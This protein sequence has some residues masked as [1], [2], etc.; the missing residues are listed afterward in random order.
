[1]LIP[2]LADEEPVQTAATA[3]L[4]SLGKPA[5]APLLTALKSKEKVIRLGT[6]KALGALGADAVS[7]IPALKDV[8]EK[9]ADFHVRWQANVTLRLLHFD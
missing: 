3:A 4:K 6:V 5:V 8:C 1:V 7:A 9:D 2:L